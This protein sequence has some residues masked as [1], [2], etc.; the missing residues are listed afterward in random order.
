MGHISLVAFCFWLLS[1]FS[2]VA[3][4]DEKRKKQ[5]ERLTTSALESPAPL[6]TLTTTL[7]VR[8]VCEYRSNILDRNRHNIYQ[9]RCSRRFGYCDGQRRSG[10]TNL[11]S[12]RKVQ[13]S[14]ISIYIH[15]PHT[16]KT[17]H[18]IMMFKKFYQQSL[19]LKILFSI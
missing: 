6:W 19:L 8:I 15:T 13:I 17:S 12:I 2:H 18:K 5:S 9:E 10:W 11:W 3:S 7:K 4:R 16:N 14:I 1:F